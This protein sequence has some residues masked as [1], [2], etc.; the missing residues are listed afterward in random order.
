MQELR[1]DHC[2]QVGDLHLRSLAV[3]HSVPAF[4][5][6]AERDGHVVAY[7]GDTNPPNMI[8]TAVDLAQQTIAECDR[9]IAS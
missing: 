7:S 4:G 5:L 9:K 8:E 6:R 2:A 3:A 1:D